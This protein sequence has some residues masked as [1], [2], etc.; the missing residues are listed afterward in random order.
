MHRSRGVTSEYSHVY[1]A[2]G[3][4]AD[5]FGAHPITFDGF[6][7]EFQLNDV[8]PHILWLDPFVRQENLNISPLQGMKAYISNNFQEFCTVE[9]FVLT[10]VLEVFLQHINDHD[11]LKNMRI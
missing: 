5:C 8:T 4:G 11:I 1:H 7:N 10:N 3:D 6:L 9:D 2:D